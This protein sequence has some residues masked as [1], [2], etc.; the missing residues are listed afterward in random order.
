MHWKKKKSHDQKGEQPYGK[1]RI[2]LLLQYAGKLGRWC[3][4]QNRDIW[5]Q[6][7]PVSF[8]EPTIPQTTLT[9]GFFSCAAHINILP[10]S[11]SL[12]RLEKILASWLPV[13]SGRTLGPS[14]T[15]I[16]LGWEYF[17][18]K[19]DCTILFIFYYGNFLIHKTRESSV[20]NFHT[21]KH[22]F[23]Q[24]SV[25]CVVFFFSSKSHIHYSPTS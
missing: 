18:Y 1:T 25:F 5:Q 12:T 13:G 16:V 17:P 24:L 2:L 6:R 10:I 8:A 3:V 7:L 11:Y 20:V 19:H 4:P 23:L 21:P 9:T 14:V 22:Q 15:T